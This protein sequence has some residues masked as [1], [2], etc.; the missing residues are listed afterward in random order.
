MKAFNDLTHVNLYHCP[1]THTPLPT[2]DAD[3]KWAMHTH[4]HTHRLVCNLMFSL[5]QR[6]IAMTSLVEYLDEIINITFS[7]SSRRLRYIA[8]IEKHEREFCNKIMVNVP[9]G[10]CSI[11]R[12]ASSWLQKFSLLCSVSIAHNAVKETI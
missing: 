1:N 8:C 4:T 2:I 3:I 9:F 6:Y 10:Y 11:Q 7:V 12:P 5:Y